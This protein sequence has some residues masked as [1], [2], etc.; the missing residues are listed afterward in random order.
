MKYH[1]LSFKCLQYDVTIPIFQSWFAYVTHPTWQN[2]SS[3]F[4][5]QHIFVKTSECPKAFL[6]FYHYEN[7]IFL[8]LR[9]FDLDLFGYKD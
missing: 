8:W 4:P 7:R 2:L 3:I 6:K 5:N 1:E 9:Y